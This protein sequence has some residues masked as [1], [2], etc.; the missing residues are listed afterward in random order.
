MARGLFEYTLTRGFASLANKFLL[1]SKMLESQMWNHETPFYQ[2]SNQLTTS[3]LD[4]VQKLGLTVAKVKSPEMTN[5]MLSSFMR[6]ESKGPLLKKLANTLP[7][8]EIVTKIQPI[9]RTISKVTLEIMASFIWNDSFNGKKSEAF[10]IWLQDAESE[11]I[12]YHQFFKLTKQQVIRREVQTLT[13]TIPLLDPDHIPSYYLIHYDSDKWL[14]CEQEAAISCQ[15]LILP[16]KFLPFT[17]LLD[18]NPL[19]LSA[20]N[21]PLYESI[22]SF[23]HF[24]PIQT[25]IFHTLYHTDYNV[26]LG[27]P[28]G[29]GKTNCAEIAMFR[30][31]NNWTNGKIVYIAPLKA[32][33]RE[34]VKDWKARLEPVL[35]KNVIEL[36]GDTMPDVKAISASDI[37]VTTPEKWDGV[38]RSWQSRKY[39]RD[40]CLIIID[41]IHL[42]GEDRGPVLEVIV[43]R[44]NFI[45]A[46]VEKKI[47]IIGLSTAVANAQDLANWLNIKKLGLYNFKPSVRPVPLE[48]HISGFPGRHYCPRMASMNKPAYK[49]IKQHSANKPVI[50]FVSSRR[51]TRLTAL[52]LIAF[53]AQDNPKQWLN[54]S[55]EEIDFLIQNNINDSNLKLTLAFGVGLHH[56]GLQDKDR[57]LVEELF[58]N[59][60]I[61]IL[62]TTATL[63]WGVNLP[64]HL[65]I[66][67]GTEFYDGKTHRYVDFPITDVLQMMGR[68]GRPQFDEKGK[69]VILVHDIKKE[70]YKKFLYE[71][72]PVESHLVSVI[73][74]HLN[75]EIV[76]GTIQTKSE[77]IDYLTWTYL[78]RR[79]FKNPTYYGLEDAFVS[80]VNTFLTH[81]VDTSLTA[82]INSNCIEIDPEND[83]M[84]FS[85]S[86]GRIASYYYLHHTTVKMFVEAFNSD[87]SVNHLLHL[88]SSAHEYN[89]LPVRHNEDLLNADLAKECRF[90]VFENSPYNSSHTKAYLLLQAHFSRL[91][92]PCSDYITDL[93][94]VL[95]QSIRILMAMIDVAAMS[96]YLT[97]VLRL[98]QILQ[99]IS[100]AVWFDDASASFL[101]HVNSSVVQLLSKRLSS[102]IPE[103]IY[104]S[105]KESYQV[106]SKHL[107]LLLEEHQIIELFD[108]IQN[109][110]LIEVSFVIS[111]MEESESTDDDQGHVIKKRS[112]NVEAAF[113]N[114]SFRERKYYHFLPNCGYLLTL[115]LIRTQRLTKSG[116]VTEKAYA[117][118]FPKPKDE[119]WIVIV[120]DCDTQELIALKKIGPISSK[121]VQSVD[122][123]F[124][125]PETS[126]RLIYTIFLLSDCYLGLDQQ[127]ELGLDVKV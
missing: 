29:S 38:S 7:S 112:F 66:I 76:A 39:V 53:V 55:E 40:V 11:H 8:L 111:Q 124:K 13:F 105:K 47:R 63:A 52:D 72:F 122:L 36:T 108:V 101:P 93:K 26:M 106:F 41:E 75:A 114:N 94:S 43:S 34:R 3:D 80:T 57:S 6:I 69:A 89:E 99:M 42:L 67:K 15:N 32:L 96:G 9:T 17:K 110:P 16:E 56:A 58:L 19:P 23:T 20:L 14:G 59:Q 45:S 70:F 30:V 71:P 12:Y 49:A 104:I 115:K 107:R 22:Y 91:E 60:K 62:V 123:F 90:S 10:W 33:V 95:D 2:F 81:L 35:G 82:L 121:N 126:A 87:N 4:K 127:Y 109:L 28:T 83:Q 97:T 51:Q 65:V 68:A 18:L 5:K 103:L 31:F 61:Q 113:P 116:K 25:Q 118:M 54:I 100:Q 48:V 50:V 79:I 21:N 73:E 24:N 86:I 77:C 44:T 46:N 117:P 78:F 92:L 74:D 85:T 1:L 84:L 27:A 37:I 64:A 125:T 98:I 102:D 120:G 119:N 88:L